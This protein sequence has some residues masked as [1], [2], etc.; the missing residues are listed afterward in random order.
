[1]DPNVT[2]PQGVL[3]ALAEADLG[4]ETA[5]NDVIEINSV[6]LDLILNS[7][8]GNHGITN[9][10]QSAGNMNNQANVVSISFTH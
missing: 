2:A 5:N 3:V 4:Q 8:N 7:V 9:V 10:N 6:K 1:V